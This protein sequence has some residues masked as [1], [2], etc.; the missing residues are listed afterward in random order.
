MRLQTN[1]ARVLATVLVGACAASVAPAFAENSLAG[2]SWQLVAIHSM[3]DAQGT[4]VMA[5]PERFTLA[6][7]ADG[8]AAFR[9]DCNRGTGKYEITPASDDATGSI[10]FGPIAVTRMMCPPPS[11]DARVAR[12]MG[13]VRG[14]LLK[15]GKLHL[16]LMADGGIYEWAPMPAKIS[17]EDKDRIVKPVRFARGKSEV[18]IRDRLVGRQYVDYQVQAAAGQHMSIRL[19]GSNGAGYFNLLPPDSNAV[20]MA[21]GELSGNRFD[22]QLP[23][24]GVYTVR[25]FLMRSAARRNQASNY[26]L[27]VGIAGTPLKPVSPQVDAVIPGTRYHARS[28]TTCEPRYS[29]AREC[30]VYVVRRGFDG[31]ATVE[32]RWM[33]G[34]DQKAMRRILFVKGE[35]RAAD[36]PSAMTFTRSSRGWRVSFD[37]E[38]HFE[39]P[40]PLVN[41]G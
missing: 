17:A 30:E 24:D 9:L 14:Y 20:A 23:D 8:Q 3:D 37:G 2:T 40:E 1:V 4:T 36:T 35:P 25:V 6:L 10:A 19:T 22:G 33:G 29:Q 38:E 15:D 13:Y 16:S 32:L 39:V 7:G 5:S 41:G 27:K 34:S 26:T 28:T 12:D 21:V 31:T 18:L 11:L